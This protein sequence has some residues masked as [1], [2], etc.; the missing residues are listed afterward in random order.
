MIRDFSDLVVDLS[1][2]T[3]RPGLW[4]GGAPAAGSFDGGASL[5]AVLRDCGPGVAACGGA[6]GCVA[7][8]DWLVTGGVQAGGT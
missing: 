6:G 1:A 7:G 8:P 3:V 5:S 2:V 4:G